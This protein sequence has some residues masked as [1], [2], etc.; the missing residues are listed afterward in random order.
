VDFT[1]NIAFSELRRE[2]DSRRVTVFATTAVTHWTGQNLSRELSLP[3]IARRGAMST[4]TL[5][6]RFR[7]EVGTTP[8][9]WLAHP[10]VR[11]AQRLL[12]AT[13]LTVAQVASEG[14]FG[15]AAVMRE[16]FGTVVGQ[17]APLRSD[18]AFSNPLA[19]SHQ[20]ATSASHPLRRSRQKSNCAPS[21]KVRGRRAEIGWLKSAE[22]MFPWKA[23]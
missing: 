16:R 20:S 18:A 6:R 2:T 5:S 15:S 17:R 14:G 23:E 7:A 10:R 12:E 13:D 21:W 3:L 8:A 22:R 1:T 4:R 19:I 9:A 11:C